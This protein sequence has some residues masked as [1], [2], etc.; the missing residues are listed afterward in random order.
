[1]PYKKRIKEVQSTVMADVRRS[2]MAL[3]ARI[4]E[5]RAAA[6]P[7][8]CDAFDGMVEGV[9]TQAELER[10]KLMGEVGAGL[11]GNAEEQEL[12]RRLGADGYARKKGK[13]SR[14]GGRAEKSWSDEEY[15]S[16]GGTVH[17][18]GAA[19]RQARAKAIAEGK[20]VPSP[21]A[22][23]GKFRGPRGSSGSPMDRLKTA[24]WEMES[25]L[26]RLQK[27]EQV[28]TDQVR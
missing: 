14:I 19:A 7:D 23:T 15:M 28:E 13:G 12:L 2:N 11:A 26:A 21:G 3:S 18:P 16:D 1:L 17:A 27:L 6:G 5:A 22:G 24:Q 4:S 25:D 10:R 9:I 8:I 20:L